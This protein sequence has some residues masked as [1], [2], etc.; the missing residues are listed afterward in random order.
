MKKVDKVIWGV[1]GAG[2]VCEIKSMPAMYSIPGSAVK[3]VMRRNAAKVADFARRHTIPNWTTD[4]DDVLN[5]SD[6]NAIYIATPPDSHPEL[7]IKAAQ[8][9]KAVYVEKPMANSYAE[10]LA[11]I[12][13]CEKAGVPL[14]VAYYRRVL[15]GFVKVKELIDTGVLGDIRLVN[16]EM[17]QALQPELIARS[18]TNWRV[19]PEISGG[20][21]FQDL[22]SHQLDY[23]DFLFGDI[24]DA[25]GIYRNQ[26]HLYSADDIVTANFRFK[27]GVVGSGVWCFSTDIV[28]EK[29]KITIVGS[30][31]ELSFNT[32]GNPMVIRLK[33]AGNIEDE[34][35]FNHVQPIQKPL[36]QKIVNELRSDDVSPSTGITAAR[37]TRVMDMICSKIRK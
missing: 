33:S 8:A 14:F 17:Y 27:N 36:I 11:M 26:A 20:G 25:M 5:D 1:I 19:Q 35:E 37:T 4:L 30:K 28:S 9:G 6:I 3:T 31:G 16:I 23:L 32:F 13:A 10:C 2:N 22:A 15:P 18:E 29:D 21:Y 24:V 7:T 12:E 34:L